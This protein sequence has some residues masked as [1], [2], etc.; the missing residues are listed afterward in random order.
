MSKTITLRLA[1]N[2]YELFKGAAVSENR[3]IAN[4]IVTKAKEKIEE[5][6]FT[7]AIETEEIRLNI[8]LKKR[9]KTGSLQ[10]KKRE[11]KIVA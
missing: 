2:E 10:A 6:G 5:E 8:L 9:L 7:D 3:A 4:L 1:E 11:G